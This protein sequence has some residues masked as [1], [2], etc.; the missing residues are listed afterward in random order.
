MDN[1]EL[2]AG[3]TRLTWQ[4]DGDSVH[5]QFSLRSGEAWRDVLHSDPARPG[6][7]S[8]ILGVVTEGRQ[9][10]WPVLPRHWE[11]QPDQ[12]VLEAR[13]GDLPIQITWQA[14]AGRIHLEVRARFHWAVNLEYAAQPLSLCAGRAALRGDRAPGSGLHAQP[15]PAAG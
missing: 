4:V 14:V 11:V 9:E 12:V 7:Q 2:Q 5:E 13:A 8:L 3:E 10:E 15:A 6:L 1:L